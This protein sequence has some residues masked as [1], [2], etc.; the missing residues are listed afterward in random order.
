MRILVTNDDGI[1][2][3]GIWAL[4]EAMSRVGKTLVVA[5]EKQQS[6]VGT[7][8]SLHSDMSITEVPSSIPDVRAYAVG[9]TPSDCVIMGLRRLAQGHIDLIVSGINLGANVG[10]D[11]LYSGT[12]MATLQGF[13]RGLPSIAIS[14]VIQNQ[15]DKLHFDVAAKVAE[16]LIQKIK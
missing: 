3:P 5:P 14:L 8:V 11:I 15:E 10:R 4:A 16:L 2:S 1:D 6:G 13:F 7:A 9:G 12:V